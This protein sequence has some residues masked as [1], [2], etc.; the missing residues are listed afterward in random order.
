MSDTIEKKQIELSCKEASIF[1]NLKDFRVK[2]YSNISQ[3]ITIPGRN[4][5]VRQL[6]KV[7]EWVEANQETIKLMTFNEIG[8]ALMEM[9]ISTND[10]CG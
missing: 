9:D 2:D 3:Q 1:V 5:G 6:K 4:C 7:Y 10:Y 8:K